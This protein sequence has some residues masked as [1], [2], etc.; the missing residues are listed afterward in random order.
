MRK[1]ITNSSLK[2]CYDKFIA[3]EHNKNLH[4]D[5]N[6]MWEQCI[7]AITEINNKSSCTKDTIDKILFLMSRDSESEE[8][9][10]ILTEKTLIGFEVAK[11]GSQHMDSSIRWQSAFLLGYFGDDKKLF[12]M[13]T[14]DLDEYVRR[15]A[16]IALREINQKK[17]EEISLNKLFS[18]YEYE[19]MIALD[20]LLFLN[21]SQ[22]PKAIEIL[23]NDSS[24]VV[25]AK[26][27]RK[28]IFS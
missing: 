20:T 18:E 6:P 23:K 3:W 2:K 28:D 9:M 14:K 21:S 27:P 4:T 13:A 7:N 19:R 10:H 26:L 12:S 22:L 1:S 15:R 16:L 17:A 8:I 11:A 24:E 5:D 25:Q